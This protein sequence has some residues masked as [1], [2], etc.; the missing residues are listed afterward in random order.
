MADADYLETLIHT[1]DIQAKTEGVADAFNTPAVTW[2]DETTDVACRLEV[3][4]FDREVIDNQAI[5]IQDYNLFLP[6]A[7][8]ITEEHR[9][10]MQSGVFSGSTFSVKAVRHADDGEAAHHVE[11][12]LDLMKG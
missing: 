1:C 9:V 11:A 10:V 2:P 3:T 12:V 7:T 8:T 4:I 5:V 6:V